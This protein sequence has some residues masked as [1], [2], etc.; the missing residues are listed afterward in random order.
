MAD[1]YFERLVRYEKRRAYLIEQ[2][3]LAVERAKVQVEFRLAIRDKRILFSSPEGELLDLG[4][5]LTALGLPEDL[6]KSAADSLNH[7]GLVRWQKELESCEAE[8][9]R[10]EWTSSKEIW[11]EDLLALL[12]VWKATAYRPID[13]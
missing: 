10:L 9:E 2:A 8:L 13:D 11:R 5:Q 3:K 7:R 4:P 6:A 1:F 12:E